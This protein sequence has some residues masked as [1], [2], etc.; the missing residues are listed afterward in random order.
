MT[1]ATD[2]NALAC[3]IDGDE[4]VIPFFHAYEEKIIQAEKQI[5]KSAAREGCRPLRIK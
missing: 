4:F 5:I 2:R 3:R 1:A